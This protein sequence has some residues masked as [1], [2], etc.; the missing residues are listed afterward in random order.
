VFK[1][2]LIVAL[3]SNKKK[4]FIRLSEKKS[5]IGSINF[6]RFGL[7]RIKIAKKKFYFS[8]NTINLNQIN[9]FIRRLDR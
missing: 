7:I 2:L 3:K 5:A 9:L 8:L 1:G 6:I 4:F